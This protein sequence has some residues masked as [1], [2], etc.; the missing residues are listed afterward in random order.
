MGQLSCRSHPIEGEDVES[1]L[2]AALA[3]AEQPRPGEALD[4]GALPRTDGLR[5]HAAGSRAAAL[6]LDEGHQR[7]PASDEVEIVP[8]ESKAMGF[9]PPAVAHQ[10]P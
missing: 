7:P 9:D 10:P 4:G 6:H 3:M 1:V 2:V 5:P 8:A